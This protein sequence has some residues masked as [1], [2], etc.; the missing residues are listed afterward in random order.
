MINYCNNNLPLET[1]NVSSR[2]TADGVCNQLSEKVVILTDWLGDY[3]TGCQR[4][5]KMSK[6]VAI[7]TRKA[8]D[9][10]K[11]IHKRCMNKLKDDITSEITP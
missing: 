8:D 6:N 4:P 1:D 9:L 7:F 2:S 11:K 5:E 10:T 3:A